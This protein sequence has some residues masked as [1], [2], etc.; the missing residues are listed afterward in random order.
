MSPTSRTLAF[1]LLAPALAGQTP[2]AAFFKGDPKTIALF[3]AQK[4]GSLEPK[5]VEPLA[6]EARTHLA[7]GDR[8]KAEALFQ[9]MAKRSPK[10]DTYELIAETWLRCGVRESAI[11]WAEK[12]RTTGIH[13]DGAL[14]HLAVSLMDAGLDKDANETMALAL[15]AKPKDRGNFMDFA[16]ACLR[17]GRLDDARPWLERALATKP[18]EERLWQEI[19]MALADN[20]LEH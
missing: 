17:S 16:R 1:L 5:D 12:V 11:P 19:A 10:P 2:D 14:T 18:K 9:E 13:D 4:A 3:C 7:S 15:Q 6:A 20:G 8:V